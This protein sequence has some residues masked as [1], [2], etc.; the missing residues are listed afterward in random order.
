MIQKPLYIVDEIGL[1]VAAVSTKMLTYLQTIDSAIQGVQYY[2]GHPREILE[3]LAQ[4]DQTE[5]FR[6]QKYPAICLF[7]DFSEVRSSERGIYATSKFQLI[8]VNS[9]DPNYKAE[10]RYTHNFKPILYPIYLNFLEQI[11]LSGKCMLSSDY[12]IPHTKFDRVFWGRDLV[13]GGKNSFNDYLD[14]IEIVSMELKWYR[15]NC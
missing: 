12:I 15:P 4:K 11:A 7:Q 6:F 2:Y 5:P 3:T 8:I 10:E 9:T 13:D 1:I 14:A